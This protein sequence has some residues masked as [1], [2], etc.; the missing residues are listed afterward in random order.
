MAQ[1]R[2]V[3][4][5]LRF[6]QSDTE[7]SLPTMNGHASPRCFS[8]Q[9]RAMNWGAP[10]GVLAALAVGSAARADEGQQQPAAAAAEAAAA[11]EQRGRLVRVPL[12]VR[13]TVP[14]VIQ[15]VIQAAVA[16]F[17]DQSAAAAG[18][19]PILILELDPGRTEFGRGGTYTGAYELADFLLDNP[20]L[21]GIRTVAYVPR[22]IKGHGVLVAM[23]CEELVMGPD[24]EIGAAGVDEPADIKQPVRAAYDFVANRRRT[25]PRAVALGMLDKRLEVHK[26]ETLMSLHFVLQD[27]LDTFRR[28]HEVEQ[29]E[30]LIRRGDWGLFTG[31]EARQL[32]FARYLARDRLQLATAL[33]L[34][35]EAVQE[36]PLLG[37][38]VEARQVMIEGPLSGQTVGRIRS[39]IDD[40]L[41]SGQVNFLCLRIDSPGGPLEQCVALAN[42][43]ADL[44]RSAVRTVAYVP[45][46]AGAGAALVALACDH[47][48]MR[49]EA[50]IGGQEPLDADQAASARDAIRL[51]AKAK[52][53]SW[54]PLVGLVDPTLEIFRY[55][56]RKNGRQAFFSGEEAAEQEDPAVWDRQAP[57]SN[58]DEPLELTGEQAKEMGLAWHT[59]ESFD[60]LKQMY[61]LAD[62][63]RLVEPSWADTLV[64]ALAHP[65]VAML[66]LVIGGAALYTELQMP[67]IGIGGFVASVAFLL[68][69]WSKFLYGTA[70]WLEVLLF[71]A[72]I[73]CLLLEVF[74]IPGFGIFGLGGG[75][76]VIVSLVLASQTFVLP[77]TSAELTELRNSMLVVAGAGVGILG[78][79]A[80]LRRYFR[81]MPVLN[82]LLLKPPETGRWSDEGGS[83]PE[84]GADW[85]HLE[86]Q[87]GTTTTQLTPSGKARIDGQL[88]DVLAD[89]EVIERG[90]RVVVVEVHGNRIVV[91]AD[92][93]ET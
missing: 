40:E 25:I 48:V 66:L 5:G 67:G 31:R 56:H 43:I 54:S 4:F 85:K 89:G 19:R 76:M 2:L 57:I 8:P 37:R 42:Y 10:F 69:F 61:G 65:A 49:P 33:G 21:R 28:D 16:D 26:V 45:N 9:R 47:L 93:D 84:A 23:A 63:P 44:D 82:H 32:G 15:Q 20:E 78:T 34:P 92:G 74:V 51:L 52:G 18:P 27:E 14:A 64:D 62:D 73:C 86:G 88:V 90:T 80:L 1:A 7:F 79:T 6:P 55:Q 91:Q 12:P 70:E 41:R 35:A 36:D 46:E 87:T 71:L 17:R 60:E 83:A 11:V 30:V 24:A 75:L 3:G 39:M 59:V 29:E 58:K 53:R 72:G 50:R 81:H 77:Y 38:P 68:F 22:S 13:G